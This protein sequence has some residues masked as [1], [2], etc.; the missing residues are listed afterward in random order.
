M[1]FNTPLFKKI[2]EI[3]SVKPELFDMASF[4]N[5]GNSE[6]GTTRCIAGWAIHLETGEPLYDDEGDFTAPVHEL[7]DRLGV[8]ADPEDLGRELLG[9]SRSE[10]ARL[11][12][13]DD[14]AG[15]RFV[16]LAAQGREAEAL[17]VL[18]EDDKGGEW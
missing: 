3:I 17:E 15:T 10:A 16:E 18:D 9:L 5:G 4:E 7:A 12:Y 13:I 2:R 14:E 6:C 11:F 8:R 1:S